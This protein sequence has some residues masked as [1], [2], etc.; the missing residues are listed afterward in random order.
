MTLTAASLK[1]AIRKVREIEVANPL[2]SLTI[3]EAHSAI[4]ETTER[5]F[6]ESRHRSARIL[7]KLIKRYGSEFRKEPAVFRI[8]NTIYAHPARYREL[9]TY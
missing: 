7:K 1:N 8:G 6:P 5:L 4:A 2:A 9:T 3:I